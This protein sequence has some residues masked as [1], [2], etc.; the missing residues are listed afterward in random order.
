M[1][2]FTEAVT[3]GAPVADVVDIVNAVQRWPSWHPAVS[4]VE[5]PG[6][7]PLTVG[8]TVTVKQPRLP[9]ATW[10]VTEVDGSGFAWRSASLGVRSTGEH[11]AR[12]AADGRSAV[13]LTLTM[14]GPLSRL[15]GL[16]Y[17][18]LIRRYIRA[19]ATGLRQEAE[20]RAAG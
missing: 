15:V 5:R 20:R 16:V 3:I 10:T 9:A 13:E 19:E 14:S 4:R 1:I 7:G 8:E 2:T 12:E 11:W 6:S 17:S 18:P